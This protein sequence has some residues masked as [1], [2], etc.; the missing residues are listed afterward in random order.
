IWYPVSFTW[1]VLNPLVGDRARMG[2][3]TLGC[4]FYAV[5]GRSTASSG[6][7]GTNDNQLFNCPCAATPTP[8]PT[9]TPV[10]I[11]VS[12][13]ILQCNATTGNP[14][15]NAVMTMTGSNTGS[16]LTDVA[17]NYTLLGITNSGTTTVTPTKAARAPG[18][19]NI[20][21]TDVIAIQRHFLAISLLTGCRLAAADC[22]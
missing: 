12:G 19:A 13:N 21:T 2:G 6:F 9:P 5:G 22:A 18:S 11:N 1:S 7:V 4:N 16:T 10:T 8:T 17:G 20:N 14:M 3:G 15:Q